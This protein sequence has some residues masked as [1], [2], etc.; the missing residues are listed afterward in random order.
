MFSVLTAAIRATGQQGIIIN[1]H[2]LSDEDTRR[3]IDTLGHC[4]DFIGHDDLPRRMEHPSKKPFCLMTFD[5]GKKSNLGTADILEEKGVPAVFYIVTDAVDNPEPLWFDCYGALVKKLRGQQKPLPAALQ[6]GIL[7]QLPN[8]MREQRVHEACREH[9]VTI[10]RDDPGIAPM[11]WDDLQGL[12]K[13]GFCLGAHTLRHEILTTEQRQQALD[14]VS[15]SMAAIAQHTAAPCQSFAFPN[16]NYTAQLA[17]Q[18]L[19]CGARTVMTTEPTW[20]RPDM[21]L[22]R[23]PRIQL[24]A[25]FSCRK[26]QMKLLA[27]AC[28]ALKNPDGTG[29]LYRRIRRM[30]G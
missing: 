6:P 25:G 8:A 24:H 16:G 22:W 23:L 30:G 4:F 9:G 11:G 18:A 28:A 21:P 5:D 7:K 12:H 10:D 17:K 14:N 27:A 15:Q 3:N 19:D 2:T 20:V 13:R 26:I 1:Y 29:R